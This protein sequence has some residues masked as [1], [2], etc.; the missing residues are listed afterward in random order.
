MVKV[1]ARKITASDS[2]VYAAILTE[3]YHMEYRESYSDHKY[4]ISKSNTNAQFPLL[5]VYCGQKATHGTGDH[6]PARCFLHK[7]YPSGSEVLVTV[8]SCVQ[9]NNS[10]SADE[11]YVAFALKYAKYGETAAEVTSFTRYERLRA[12]LFESSKGLTN[13][14][15]TL[16]S[17]RLFNVLSK[18]AYALGRYECSV[19]LER[20]PISYNCGNINELN[21]DE[22]NSFNQVEI[23]SDKI[24]EIGSR[25][26][27]F[28]I[29]G[30]DNSN[31][32]IF[33]DWK[34]VQ[35]DVFRYIAFEDDNT[36]TV[37]MV[38]EEL[39]YSEVVFEKS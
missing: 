28:V 31:A 12:H 1:A 32:G 37:K 5:C 2:R 24:P 7:P 13:S 8:S 21:S 10:T 16:D 30:L 3:D 26:S 27:Q 39:L 17:V 34:I 4:G 33:V 6:I 19:F 29:M 20:N 14:E 15:I 22:Y 9:C 23:I 36:V 18:Y 35:D 25:A 11:E 38:F